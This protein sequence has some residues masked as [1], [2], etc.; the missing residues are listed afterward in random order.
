MLYVGKQESRGSKPGRL[1][2]PPSTPSPNTMTKLGGTWQGSETEEPFLGQ[3]LQEWDWS[4]WWLHCSSAVVTTAA[5]WGAQGSTGLCSLPTLSLFSQSSILG[6][7]VLSFSTKAGKL[8][9]RGMRKGLPVAERTQLR[10]WNLHTLPL[11]PWKMVLLLFSSPSS[12]CLN[13]APG[14][15]S[16]VWN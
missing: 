16:V 8:Q 2:F 1:N 14:M 11:E 3:T 15:I 5:A 10:P 12:S 4:T 13:H 7:P 6:L 9:L